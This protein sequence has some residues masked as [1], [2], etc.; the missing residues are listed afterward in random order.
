MKFCFLILH[1]NTYEKTIKCIN[2]ILSQNYDECDIVVIDNNS[3]N[4]SY[5]KLCDYAKMIARMEIIRIDENLGFSRG[6]NY[7]YAKV[8]SRNYDFIVVCN[9]DIY[10]T[11]KKTLIKIAD[12]YERTKFDLLGPDIY[13]RK[14]HEH[15]NPVSNRVLSRND[16]RE[17]INYFQNVLYSDG[18]ENKS[19]FKSKLIKMD[20]LYIRNRLKNCL[21]KDAEF[22]KSCDNVRLFGA[23]LIFSKK[24]IKN[25]EKLF[26]PETYFYGE[27]EILQL[28]CI[29]NRYSVWYCS[30][31]K[32]IH[33]HGGTTHKRYKKRNDLMKFI[34]KNQ[35]ESKRI[36]I[37]YY[38]K[39]DGKDVI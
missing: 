8:K 28:R 6:N 2:S 34:A 13:I 38:N 36:Y 26:Y 7:G 25:E 29:H 5:E 1:Y 32:V 33:D 9:N 23:C 18:K 39:I 30:E 12:F 27:E 19:N 10:F 22:K 24:F 3:T 31:I 17:I 15:Q 14:K 35:I 20:I 11:D 37:E 21:K 4:D 16:A